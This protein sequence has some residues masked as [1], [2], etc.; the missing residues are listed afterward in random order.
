MA[1][2]AVVS[3]PG[4]WASGVAIEELYQEA[5]DFLRG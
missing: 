5:L 4:P 2:S 1:L 3:Y